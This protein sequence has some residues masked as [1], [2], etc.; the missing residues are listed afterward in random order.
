MDLRNIINL[1]NL[2]IVDVREPYEFAAGHVEGSLNIPL[3]SVPSR[4]EEF[5]KMGQ[6]IILYCRSGNRSGQAT[7][8]LRANGILESYNGGSLEEVEYYLAK[9]AKAA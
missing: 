9:A 2:T 4:L 6:P 3:G 1:P 8:F 7:G 5:R